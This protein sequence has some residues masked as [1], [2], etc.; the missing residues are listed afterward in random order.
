M[1][2]SQLE[3]P[4]IRRYKLVEEDIPEVEPA[5]ISLPQYALQDDFNSLKDELSELRES[6]DLLMDK[7]KE[8]VRRTRKKEEE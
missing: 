5:P 3:S 1:G 7:F 4:R 2:F 8:P 6:M